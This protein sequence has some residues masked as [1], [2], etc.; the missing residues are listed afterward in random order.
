MAL[1][2]ALALVLVDVAAHSLKAGQLVE[3]SPELIKSLQALGAADPHKDAVAA[4]KSAGAATVRSA[5]ELQAE[6][7]AAQAQA[8][9][10]RIAELEQ[11]REKAEPA[12]RADLE[13][14]LVAARDALAALQG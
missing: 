9:Q 10:A 13:A 11:Q 6:E 8:L 7:R 2:L 5:L 4:A 3:A 1:K 14:E 12:A